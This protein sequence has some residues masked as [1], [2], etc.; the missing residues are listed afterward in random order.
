MKVNV[1]EGAKTESQRQRYDVG[2]FEEREKELGPKVDGR[3]R[4]LL[5]LSLET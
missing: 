2:M 1:R 4:T 3:R 5:L